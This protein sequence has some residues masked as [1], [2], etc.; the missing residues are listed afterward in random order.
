MAADDT[1]PLQDL[2]A[3][4]QESLEESKQV[5]KSPVGAR[6]NAENYWRDKS[7]REARSPKSPSTNQTEVKIHNSASGGDKEPQKYAYFAFT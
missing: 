4:L 2:I 6:K 3:S 5:N 7:Q 1:W